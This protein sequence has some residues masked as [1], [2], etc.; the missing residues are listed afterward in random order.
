MAYRQRPRR[1][2]RNQRTSPRDSW[3][4][5]LACAAFLGHA[6]GA[7]TVFHVCASRARAT[8]LSAR[9]M[10]GLPWFLNGPARRDVSAPR[11]PRPIRADRLW[12]TAAAVGKRQLL[13]VQPRLVGATESLTAA[14]Y[15]CR[16]CRGS[17]LVL[18]LLPMAA[19][20][21]HIL[22]PLRGL[23]PLSLLPHGVLWPA[24]RE[25]ENLKM[26]AADLNDRS[27]LRLLARRGQGLHQATPQM[28][29]APR[30]E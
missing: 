22:P 4:K 8:S 30:A 11:L 16:P 1:P 9:P 3:P 14:D 13:A 26:K 2:R 21:G 7:C 10:R 28:T 6:G 24:E 12:P 27:A 18:L 23:P 20:M 17:F 29:S 19:A 5:G 25:P 15:L